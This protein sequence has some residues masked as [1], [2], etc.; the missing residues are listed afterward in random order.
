MGRVASAIK[1]AGTDDLAVLLDEDKKYLPLESRRYIRKIVALALMSQDEEFMLKTE[2]DYLMNR[3]NAYSIATVQLNS[4]EKLSRLASILDMDLEELKKI[5]RHLKYDFVPPDNQKYDIYIPYIKLAA[6]KE[7]YVPVEANKVFLVHTVEK[8]ES[9]VSIGKK[10]GIPYSVIK[11]FNKLKS[12][13]LSLKQK[14]I[15][16]IDKKRGYA[17][18]SYM[19]KPGDS[20]ISIAKKFNMSLNRLRALNSL[21]SNNIQAGDRLVVFD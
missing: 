2:F 13:A 1:K 18:N 4:G 16:P 19:V 5:N 6:F 9:L 20:L 7:R 17:Q 15:I 12:S 11:D 10:Y 3:G 8:G 21:T 14:L